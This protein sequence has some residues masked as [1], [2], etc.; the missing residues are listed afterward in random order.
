MSLLSRLAPNDEELEEVL[1][2][3]NKPVGS[4]HYDP[5]GFNKDTNHAAVAL[6]KWMYE[7]YFRV[8]ATGLENIPGEGR[9]LIIGNHSG[10]LP[11]DAMLLGYAVATNPHGPRAPRAMIERFFPSV[12]FLGNLMNQ[13]GAVVGDPVNCRKLLENEE[14][15]LVFPEGVRGAGKPFARRYEL[16]RFGTGFMHLAM[17]HQAPVLPV[18]IVGCEE[19]VPTPAHSKLLARALGLPYFPLTLPVVLPT[20]VRIH[21]GEPLYFPNDDVSET[22]V[23]NYVEQV[24]DSIRE[25]LKAGLEER[26]GIFR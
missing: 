9:C 21:V 16:Q 14:A 5:W 3:M 2:T 12:P 15:I 25:Q 6:F 11:I 24:K 8:E 1:K 18:G 22:Q 7:S 20:R 26:E 10:Q 23:N 4:M 13:I 17:E 19:S